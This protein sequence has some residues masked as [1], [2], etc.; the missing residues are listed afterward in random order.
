MSK[1]IELFEI[2]YIDGT[3]L[4]ASIQNNNICWGTLGKGLNLI[5]KEFYEKIP[6]TKICYIS[7]EI[8]T[9]SKY[10]S[11]Y[12]D[13]AEEKSNELSKQLLKAF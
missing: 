8:S 1:V 10:V 5:M 13:I 6:P 3:K 12:R 4:W 7:C 2:S 11:L 9:Q